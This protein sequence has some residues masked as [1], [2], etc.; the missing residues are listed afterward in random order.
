MENN[1]KIRTVTLSGD[2]IANFENGKTVFVEGALTD[3]EIQIQ[4][5]EEKKKFALAKIDTIISA[6]P[7]R[8]EAECVHAKSCGGCSFWHAT[9]HFQLKQ[10]A[11]YQTISRISK[12]ELPEFSSLIEEA[13]PDKGWRVRATYHWDGARLG[14]HA[15]KS[16]TVISAYEC[17]VVAPQIR[18]AVLHARDA[19]RNSRTHLADARFE[20]DGDEVFITTKSFALKKLADSPGI[21]GLK[22]QDKLLGKKETVSTKIQYK[23]A[24]QPIEIP[25]GL[26]R[27]AND[28]VNGEIS[29]FVE[30]QIPDGSNV[31]EYFCGY[32]N[33][34]FQYLAK[35]KSTAA[36]EASSESISVAKS[37]SKKFGCTNLAL[38][39]I[40]LFKV[41]PKPTEVVVMDPPR[42]GAQMVCERLVSGSECRKIIYVSCDPATLAR[43][44]ATLVAGGFE[45]EV[46]KFA[47]MFPRT[48]HIE[49]VV[50]LNR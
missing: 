19:F 36:Y 23:G 6:S 7:N 25:P 9:D 5:L 40:D 42:A 34:T 33:L 2:G 14:F 43:D 39:R 8:V 31:S 13:V 22:I 24:T 30:S 17:L 16:K 45:I 32:G 29:N 50:V 21:S 38:T 48:S 15:K 41:V 44:L 11:A 47:D 26:F 4:I 27:Q 28:F 3:E 35:T 1:V 18:E 49:T 20:V 10:N 46:L 12:V 37:L